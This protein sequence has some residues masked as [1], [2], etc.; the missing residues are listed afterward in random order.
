MFENVFMY[1]L[2]S[3]L[4]VFFEEMC[5]QVPFPLFDWVVSF[6]GIELYNI[7]HIISHLI[8]EVVRAKIVISILQMSN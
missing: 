4:Y 7:S 2:V 3:H 1:V 8:W 5:L 6:Y